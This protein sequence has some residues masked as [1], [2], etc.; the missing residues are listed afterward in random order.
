[1]ITQINNIPKELKKLK[2][3]CVYKIVSPKKDGQHKGKIPINP[4]TSKGASSTDPN[5]W[6]DFKTAVKFADNYDGLGFFFND[7]YIGIDIDD[8]AEEIEAFKQNPANTSNLINWLN[9]L[10]NHSYLEVSQSGKG[11][12]A[13]VKGKYDLNNN[14]R[15]NFEI[16]NHGRFFALT[17]DILNN[18]KNIKTVSKKKIKELYISTVGKDN[19]LTPVEAKPNIPS[20][21]NLSIDETIKKMLASS[22]GVKIKHL[23]DGD[24]SAFNSQ[25][26]ADIALC[27]YLAFWTNKDAAKMDTIFRQ[28]KLMRDKW[29]RKDGAM[30]Y[31]QRTINKAILDTQNGYSTS[32]DA[33]NVYNPSSE[34]TGNYIFSFNEKKQ[35]PKLINYP[36]WVYIDKKNKAHAYPSLL[37]TVKKFV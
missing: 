17:G 4:V 28:S 18:Q 2:Q 35:K 5:T 23:M 33:P 22:N 14:R 3:W 34:N 6:V 13:I 1:M 26:E 36:D 32:G 16:Y 31:G 19:R 9:S 8:I 7:D 25:S 11:I 20:D 24:I 12:H 10:I 21:N 15:N 29:D 27:N 37:E 30:T